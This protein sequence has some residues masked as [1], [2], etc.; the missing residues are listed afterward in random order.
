[1]TYGAPVSGTGTS[2]VSTSGVR[3]R[4][5]GPASWHRRRWDL[6]RGVLLF[7]VLLVGVASILLGARPSSYAELRGEV[8]AGQVTVVEIDSVGLTP[9]ATGFSTV[10]V[11]WRDGRIH[12]TAEVVSARPLSSAPADSGTAVVQGDVAADLRDLGADVAVVPVEPRS[13]VVTVLGWELPLWLSWVLLAQLVLGLVVVRFGPPPW[14][15]TRWGWTWP[16]L[17]IPPLGLVAFLLLGGPGISPRPRGEARRLTGGW[18]FLL[19]VA[20]LAPLLT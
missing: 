9:G 15:A 18:S 12:R 6:V 17:A 14:R 5:R 13:T 16:V 2:A 10:R 3:W 11:A 8:V 1:M 4:P 7:S 20:V 19:T